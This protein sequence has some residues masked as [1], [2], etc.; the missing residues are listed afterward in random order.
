[1]SAGTKGRI[2]G[3][4]LEWMAPRTHQ[5]ILRFQS[6]CGG[7]M[8]IPYSGRGIRSLKTLGYLIQDTG[9]VLPS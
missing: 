7:Y 8:H 9:P 6:Q 1:M 2:L 4:R 3:E 5:I